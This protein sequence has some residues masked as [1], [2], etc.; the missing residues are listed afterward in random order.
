MIRRSRRAHWTLAGV[1]LALG[2]LLVGCTRPDP[3]RETTVRALWYGTQDDGSLASGVTPVVVRV[4]RGTGHGLTVDRRGLEAAGA[5]QTWEAAAWSAATIGTLVAGRDPRGL[6]VSYGL[7]E[8]IDGPSAG[9][10]MA[11]GVLTDLSGGSVLPSAT[12]TGTILPS[13]GI[14]PVGGIPEKLRAAHRDGITTLLIPKGQRTTVDPATRQQVDVVDEGR[15]IGVDVVEVA[16]VDEAYGRLVGDRARPPTATVE[17]LPARMVATIETRTRTALD[18]LAVLPVRPAPTPSLT[19]AQARIDAGRQRALQRAPELLAGGDVATAFARATLA[20]RSVLAWNARTEAAEA[21]G[22]SPGASPGTAPGSTSSGTAEADR[23]RVVADQLG[24]D[25]DAELA[26]RAATPVDRLEQLTGLADAL[27]WATDASIVAETSAARLGGPMDADALGL[28][29]ADLAEARYD[30][31]E[32]LAASIEVLGEVG[33]VPLGAHADALAQLSTYAGLL[34]QA[35]DANREYDERAVRPSA[36]TEDQAEVAR[37]EALG[38]RWIA[39]SSAGGDDQVAVVTRLS[40]ALSYFVAGTTLVTTT[41][42]TAPSEPGATADARLRI[43]DPAA[44]G[45]QVDVATATAEAT[46]GRLAAR[47]V[48]SSYLRWNSAWGREVATA[49]AATGATDQI[50]L[51]GLQLQWYGDLQ[52]AVLSGVAPR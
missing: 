28:V 42:A 10:V 8:S 13:G 39:L 2:A 48:D 27:S 30:L 46:A 20:E 6:T 41:R 51:E 21:A 47:A 5:G 9:G 43:S 38:R 19:E 44:F 34:G 26:R 36:P 32:Y 1:G 14:G 35:G 37:T 17:P 33:T 7:D 22:A 16:T 12:M 50:R 31:G 23:L 4:E 24:R 49:P 52:G 40:T 29:A 15:R 25:A 3:P 18:R 45:A 11:V